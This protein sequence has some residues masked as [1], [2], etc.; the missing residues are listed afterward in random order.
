[1]GYVI[2]I[3]VGGTFTDLLLMDSST[4]KQ[5]I[6]KTSTIVEDPSV[7]VMNGLEG[8][9]EMLDKTVNGLLAETSLIVH[10]TTVTTNAVLTNNGSK[11]ALVTTE[12]FRDVL[13]M[14]RGVR[15]R[16]NLFN[17]KY[18][19][20]PALVPRDLRIGVS[21]R[22]DKGGGVMTAV[23]EDQVV[24]IA[25]KLKSEKVEAVAISFM[26]SYA[27]DA[28]EQAV[29]K[30]I[31]THLPDAFTTTSTEVVPIIRLYDRTSTAVMNAYAGPI[32]N[33]YITNLVDKLQSHD[34]NGNLLIMQSNGGVNNADAVKKLPATTLLSGP[35]AGPVAGG[36]FA[37][38]SGYDNAIVVDMG[39]TS[40]EA[41]IVRD[42]KVSIRKTG[43]INKNSISLPMADIHTIGSGG[44]SIARVNDGGLLKV[45]P[46]S[47]GATPGPV[48]YGRGGVE[49][50][51]SDANL[52]LG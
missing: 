1:M 12:G 45:G 8:F 34:F 28:H 39:G 48:S 25:E 19:A 40:F 24:A 42:G 41:S 23:D 33:Q 20:P 46:E 36:K 2:G 21:E 18:E 43:D 4:G 50:T 47:A 6:N 11:T 22:M 30:I 7:G 52:V 51:T 26:H 49:P 16:D 31:E 35:A 29:K 9:A 27:N 14:R 37:E 3:D 15:S 38:S 17:N 13:Q 44:G 5:T 32:L 10:G